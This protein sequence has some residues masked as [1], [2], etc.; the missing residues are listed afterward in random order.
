MWPKVEMPASVAKGVFFGDLYY[1]TSI[2]IRGGRRDGLYNDLDLSPGRTS[3]STS[4]VINSG[5]MNEA[6]KEVESGVKV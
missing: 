2:L 6:A 5:A 1:R 4:M 3:P